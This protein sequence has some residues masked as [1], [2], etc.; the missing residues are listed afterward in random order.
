M[1][2][3]DFQKTASVT[4]LQLKLL[5]A[6]EK[7]AQA[8]IQ[9]IIR[10]LR[11]DLHQLVRKAAFWGTLSIEKGT[12]E[13]RVYKLFLIRIKFSLHQL[14]VTEFWDTLGL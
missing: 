3:L 14:F 5:K 6:K 4:I 1:S 10:I 2:P 9:I 12:N 13:R 11:F 7:G 8:Q